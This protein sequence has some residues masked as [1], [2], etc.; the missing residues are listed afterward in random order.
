M[1]TQLIFLI[2]ANHY[3]TTYQVH[4]PMKKLLNLSILLLLTVTA[5]APGKHEVAL[6][7][8]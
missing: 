8:F 1:H 6:R 4:H 2:L 7:V 5:I 3:L